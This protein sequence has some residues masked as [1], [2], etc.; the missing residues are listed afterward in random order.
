[1]TE[2]INFTVARTFS[3]V[4][5]QS[6]EGKLLFALKYLPSVLSLNFITVLPIF[7]H[8]Y[9]FL[10]LLLKSHILTEKNKADVKFNNVSVYNPNYPN[11]TKTE[12]KN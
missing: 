1:M 6:L 7:K 10:M 2:N 11:S 9:I 8:K 5:L 4:L 3:S 12:T